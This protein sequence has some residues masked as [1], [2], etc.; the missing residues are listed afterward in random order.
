MR[1]AYVNGLP[2]TTDEYREGM[3]IRDEYGNPLILKK[4]GIRE[5]HFSRPGISSKTGKNKGPWHTAWQDTVHNTCREI[6]LKNSNGQDHIADILIHKDHIHNCTG[7]GRVIEIQHSR[8]DASIVK[9]RENFYTARGYELIWLFD[10]SNWSYTKSG[11][12]KLKKIAGN[13]C[14]LSVNIQHSMIKLFIDLGK[15]EIAHVTKIR[16]NEIEYTPINITDFC[17]YLCGAALIATINRPH[18]HSI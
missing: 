4:G 1:F 3:D 6:F 13:N 12:N 2:I 18:H 9:E 14:C 7:Q 5:A 16:K 15:K 10:A 11:K 8:M 17:H